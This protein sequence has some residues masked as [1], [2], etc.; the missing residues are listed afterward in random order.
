MTIIA[1]TTTAIA[2][3]CGVAV[4][5][6]QANDTGAPSETLCAEMP[7]GIGLYPGNPVTQMGF[8]VGKVDSVVSKG[9]HVEVVFT[10][11]GGRLFPADVQ[12][13]TRSKSILADRSLELVGNY[14]SGPT[15]EPGSCIPLRNSH[16]PKTISEVVGS[17]ADFIEALSPEGGEDTIEM[18]VT[19]L[20]ESL[21]GQGP[22]ARA[23][24][25]H[26]ASAMENPDRFVAD[27]GSSI[28]NMAPLT[29]DAL[30][31]WAAIKNIVANMP[32]VVDAGIDLWPGTIDVCVGIGW[33][34]ALLDDVQNRYGDEIWP[35]MHGQ[36]TDAIAL[37][38]ARSGDIGDLVSTVPSLKGAVDQ[39]TAQSGPLTA[40][41]TPPAIAL[42]DEEAERL[43]ALLESLSPGSCNRA[44][45][46][47]KVTEEGL[48][49]LLD[50]NGAVR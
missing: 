47:E 45:S 25:E 27:I 19:G 20:N 21:R 23:M 31:Q 46:G 26:A 24:M 38:A 42:K 29:E 32:D 48:L 30:A 37:A 17:A 10:T 49:G 43:C 6:A 22:N 40:G 15:L 36:A 13:V 33:L 4:T 12:A 35:F 39:Q 28:D 2:S 5:H 34:V 11:D 8:P 50:L 16:T 9:D 18:A 41:F 3:S 1:L 44:G 7:D 14:E